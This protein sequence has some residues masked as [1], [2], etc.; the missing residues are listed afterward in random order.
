MVRKII[1]NAASKEILA[2]VMRR[3]G[4]KFSRIKVLSKSGEG[5]AG[6]YEV[7]LK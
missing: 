5:H 7:T 2:D 4:V 1:R 6:R 3:K